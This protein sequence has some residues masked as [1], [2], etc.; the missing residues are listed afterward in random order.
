MHGPAQACIFW[1]QA[2]VFLAA[3]RQPYPALP[4]PQVAACLEASDYG[5]LAKAVFA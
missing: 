3:F 1:G 4:R 2:D 5:E